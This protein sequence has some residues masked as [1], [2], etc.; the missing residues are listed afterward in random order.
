M[1]GIGFE[2]KKVIQSGN[3]G[4]F[5]KAAFSGI[6][7]VAGPWIISIVTIMLI[8]R[9]TAAAFSE[10]PQL[11]ISVIVYTYAFS[12]IIF[13]GFHYIFTRLLADLM[14]TKENRKAASLLLF[15]SLIIG[16]V[17]GVGAFIFFSFV[18]ISV[19]HPLVFRI[20]V[21]ILFSSVNIIWLLMLFISLV[22]WYGRILILYAL[23]MGI[24]IAA[25]FFLGNSLYTAGAVLGFA[26]GH[27]AI[28]LF[29]FL[30]AF[31]AFP[32]LSLT[33]GCELILPYVKKYRSLL[34]TGYF[35]YFGLWVDKIVFWLFFGERVA[36]TGLRLYEPYDIAIYLCT[37]TMIPGLVY[38]TIFSE[39]NFYIYVRKFLLSLTSSKLRSIRQR[40]YLMFREMKK[41][42]GDQTWFQAVITVGCI[43]LVPAIL[44]LFPEILSVSVMIITLVGVFFHLLFLTSINLHF[45][46]EFYRYTLYA[47][48]LF[49]SINT[50][51]AVM[52]SL[53]HLPYLAGLNYLLST[54][55]A[56]G[57]SLSCLYREGMKV[58]RYILAGVR[59]M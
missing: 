46:L 56:A 7:I 14:Y 47:A 57:Y 39:P 38:F 15:F 23:G 17:S 11:F 19:A 34:L 33:A 32:P 5:I 55:T 2:L 44:N 52:I 51:A 41:N 27:V 21:A 35:Y 13:G 45:Y 10:A 50:V 12:L 18:N 26:L 25:M 49:F 3:I 43:I 59:I 4:S 22:T 53:L 58:D 29:L 16:T 40:K 28:A 6:M 24:A 36:G 48:L 42:L 30:L 54:A 8:K 37:L 1:A 31:T 9:F 20:S